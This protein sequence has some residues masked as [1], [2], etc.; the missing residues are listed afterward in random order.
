MKFMGKVSSSGIGFGTIIFWVAIALMFCD[1]DEKTNLKETIV[2][3]VQPEGEKSQ[4]EL[5]YEEK[6]K[7]EAEELTIEPVPKKEPQKEREF[8]PI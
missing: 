6:E 4:L 8:N 2:T 1:D 5:L 3:K 7:A